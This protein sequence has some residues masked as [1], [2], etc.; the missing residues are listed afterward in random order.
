MGPCSGW[1]EEGA[2]GW[3]PCFLLLG[4]A[5]SLVTLGRPS[6]VSRVRSK[7]GPSA[8]AQQAALSG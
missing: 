4:S 5:G 8:G 3:C 1:A 6:C 7:A 2:L